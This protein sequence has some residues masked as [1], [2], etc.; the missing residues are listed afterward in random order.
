MELWMEIRSLQAGGHSIRS[1]ARE[2]HVSRNT[3]RRVLRGGS[4]KSKKKG[5]DRFSR[6]LPF[7]NEI[8]GMLG[9]ELI[10]TRILH[11]LRRMGYTGGRSPL[12]RFI[13]ELKKGIHREKVSPRF[14]TPPGDRLSSTGRRTGFLLAAF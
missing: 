14:E 10:G 12:Y 13:K 2:L 9:Q 11:E 8:E 3:V 4:S 1:I 5:R 7:K 6:L